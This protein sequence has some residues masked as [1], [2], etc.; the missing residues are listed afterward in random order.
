MKSCQRLSKLF[1]KLDQT[2]KLDT[3]DCHPG[4]HLDFN[5]AS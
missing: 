1:K 2:V 3:M 4:K 5:R